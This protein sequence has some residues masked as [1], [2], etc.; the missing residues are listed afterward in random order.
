M[1]PE[2]R[3]PAISLSTTDAARYYA[4]RHHRCRQFGCHVFAAT[5]TWTTNE[6]SDSQI[7]YGTTSSYGAST[8][9]STSLVTSHSQT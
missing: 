6:G 9:L 7:E 8:V 1:L 4:A 3:P 5:I 2:T